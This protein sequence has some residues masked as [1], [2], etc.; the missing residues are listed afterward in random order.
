[1]HTLEQRFPPSTTSVG[2][3]LRELRKSRGFTLIELMVVVAII[4]ISASV[5]FANVT[6][7]KTSIAAQ[8]FAEDVAAEMMRARDT[9]MSQQTV[10][11]V[12]LFAEGMTSVL[13]TPGAG[14]PVITPLRSL[15]K[16]EFGGGALQDNVCLH[17]MYPLIFA[18]GVPVPATIPQT[19]CPSGS[20]D[21]PFAS[22]RF[23]PDGNYEVLSGSTSGQ[24]RNGWTVVVQDGRSA[25]PTYHLIDL[26]PTGLIRV[27]PHVTNNSD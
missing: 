15:R 24:T 1:M 5:T 4:G 27:V 23:L 11:D 3:R 7:D 13:S 2:A 26:F 17:G 6:V 18:P 21:T 12:T 8:N 22:V 25:S 9:A 14:G 10:V 20:L 16:R 19:P